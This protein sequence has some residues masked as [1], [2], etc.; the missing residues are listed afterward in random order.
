MTVTPQACRIV[1]D[2]TSDISKPL[3]GEFGIT[4]VPLTVQFGAQSF[5]DGIDLTADDFYQRLS[6]TKELPQTSQ[7]PPALFEHAYRH[8]ITRGD[9]VS[10]HLS[11]KFSGTVETARSVAAEVAPER[12][13]VVDSGSVSMGLGMC[14]LA[15]ARAAQSGASMQECAAAAQ[16]VAER[17]HVAV[18][19]ETLEYLRRGGRIG[20]A[21]AFLGGL[22]RLKPV[23]TVKDGEAFPVTRARS[24]R[25]AIDE[26]C[27]LITKF[28]RVTDVAIAHTTT[29]ED[30]AMLAQ[31]ARTLAPAATLHEVRFGPVL[32]THGGPGML[33]VA[34]VE[35]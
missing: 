24:R 11:H 34:V 26:I 13:T 9:V 5:R 2:S 15:A 35:G 30:A 6:S 16:S 10:V 7:P 32:G 33:G 27:D 18:A 29:P 17:V 12:I 14:V 28:D 25:K 8:L 22:L 31:R 23:L 20:R 19:F 21:S 1:T 4:V 3:A